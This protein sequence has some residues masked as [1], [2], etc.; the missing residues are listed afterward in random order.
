MSKHLLVMAANWTCAK[1]TAKR[2]YG[3]DR[4]FIFVTNPDDFF[5]TSTDTHELLVCSSFYGSRRCGV[6]YL[7]ATAV[8]IGFKI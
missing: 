6:P 2:H 8:S 3:P 4:T 7:I 1:E 5:F